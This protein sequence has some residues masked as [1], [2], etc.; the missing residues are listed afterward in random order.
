MTAS[1]SFTAN[2]LSISGANITPIT[3]DTSLTITVNGQSYKKKVSEIQAF[4]KGKGVELTPEQISILNQYDISGTIN[5]STEIPTKPSL[6]D[7]LYMGLIQL[8][9]KLNSSNVNR[10]MSDI[11][12]FVKNPNKVTADKI[13]GIIETFDP[14]AIQIDPKAGTYTFSGWEQAAKTALSLDDQNKMVAAP[15]PP[16]PADSSPVSQTDFFKDSPV[17]DKVKQD[18]IIQSL[19]EQGIIT[20]KGDNIT[21][22]GDKVPAPANEKYGKTIESFKTNF[23][24]KFNLIEQY[25]SIYD[26]TKD[27]KGIVDACMKATSF[28]EY[29]PSAAKDVTSATL[30]DNTTAITEAN[31]SGIITIVYEGTTFKVKAADLKNSWDKWKAASGVSDW[32]TFLKTFAYVNVTFKGEGTTPAA[33]SE[34]TTGASGAKP[35][36]AAGDNKVENVKR[37]DNQ[38]FGKNSYQIYEVINPPVKIGYFDNKFF[39]IATEGMNIVATPISGA[40]VINK[41][42]YTVTMGSDGVPIVEEDVM[43]STGKQKAPQ[44]ERTPKN[45]S[46]SSGQSAAVHTPDVK[47]PEAEAEALKLKVKIPRTKNGWTFKPNREFNSTHKGHLVG[48]EGYTTYDAEVTVQGGSFVFI[49]TNGPAYK[50]Y[51]RATNKI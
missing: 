42:A 34:S 5:S 48:T 16:P 15:I 27:A 2:S 33:S 17:K 9:S 22:L 23:I 13:S 50:A 18:S 41:I 31:I 47:K 45:N 1:I 51:N 40:F 4:A 25:F 8:P 10:L 12:S 7:T 44:T 43:A 32:A 20:M 6:L 29:D 21:F 24:N 38:T 46:K 35:A 19:S 28:Q 26:S 3:T 39:K 11:A 30:A 36:G 14:T 37:L 49:K